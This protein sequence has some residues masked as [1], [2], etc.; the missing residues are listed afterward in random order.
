[1]KKPIMPH[2]PFISHLTETSVHSRRISATI[3]DWV[4]VRLG[5]PKRP[6]GYRIKSVIN[7]DTLDICLALNGVYLPALI[8]GDPRLPPHHEDCFCV[9]TF[10]HLKEK[11]E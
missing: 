2:R 5:L 8:E 7:R 9:I 6:S 4:R 10:G 3:G 1:M 11:D